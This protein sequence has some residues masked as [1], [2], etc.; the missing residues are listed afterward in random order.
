MEAANIK[1]VRIAE[2]S[3]S[4]LEPSEGHYDMDWLAGNRCRGETPY[5]E[6]GRNADSD[7]A[8]LARPDTQK[9]FVSSQTGSAC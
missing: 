7:A 5:R 2:F 4:T 3:W 8:G 6:R 9:F 1:V